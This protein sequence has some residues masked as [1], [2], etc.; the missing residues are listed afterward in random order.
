[1]AELKK[2]SITKNYILNTA[3]QILTLVTPLITAPYISRV[4]GA[5]GVGV[6]SYTSSIVAM[7][8]LFA[9]LGTTT[10]GQRA[11]AQI[12]D[13][14]YERS[15][16]FWEIEILSVITTL[17]CSIA[18]I[19][20][21]ISYPEYT[22]YFLILSFDLFANALDISWLY[23]GLEQF[24]YIV[25]R[26][27]AVKFA[28]IALIFLLV[29]E[30]SDLWIYIAILAV[31]KF[32]GNASMW[33][34][35]KKFV[36]K[37][38]I[39]NL[40][41][42]P[43]LKETFV[44]FIPTA[45][46]SIYTYL[47]K[48]MIGAFTDSTTENGY[49]EQANKIVKMA[50]TVV[51]SLNT[52]MSSRMSY[53]FATHDDKEIRQKLEGALAFILDLSIPLTFGIAGIS[54]N[55]VP[56]FFGDGYDKVAILMILASPLVIILS[57]HN[58]LSAQYLVPSG[59]RV[60]STKGVI[61][62][63]AVNFVCNLILIPRLQSVGAVIA[64]LIAESSICIVYLYMSKEYV[65]LRMIGKY[66]PKQLISATAMLIVVLLV[67]KGHSGSIAITLIQIVAGAAVYG[68]GLLLMREK[69][70][71]KMFTQIIDRVKK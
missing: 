47:D 3:Y 27:V 24:S 16:T 69:S 22:L 33:V 55:F 14:E 51:I 34:S 45:A 66:V 7:F 11:M 37:V 8:G 28:G 52:V 40:N 53:L 25:F 61:T 31:T 44:Y 71:T 2:Q 41:I 65:P 68:L 42:K 43:H 56:W 57:M 4:L 20:F 15:K 30:K 18:W 49:Y 39:K 70:V 62:G 10:Y 35:L 63:A 50:Y 54:Y 58:F 13:N 59:Q 19:I 23:S 12:R 1:M 32:L 9:C 38:P 67:G 48:V 5:D 64:T 6:Y 60:R 17:V 21:L 29:R 26:N 36:T 46:S